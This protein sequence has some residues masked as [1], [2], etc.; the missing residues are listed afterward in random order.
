MH[1]RPDKSQSHKNY[2]TYS[3][4]ISFADSSV[5][6]AKATASEHLFDG[7]IFLKGI[8]IPSWKVKHMLSTLQ[9][10]WPEKWRGHI[11]CSTSNLKP[12]FSLP[13]SFSMWLLIPL[14]NIDKLLIFFAKIFDIVN[15]D[16]RIQCKCK[17]NK[18]DFTLRLTVMFWSEIWKHSEILRTL[19]ES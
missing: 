2:N 11:K 8:F 15:I 3:F 5:H 9:T 14:Q 4:S 1:W 13:L 10:L 19:A 17:S 18:H 7:V 16:N 12:A 6:C